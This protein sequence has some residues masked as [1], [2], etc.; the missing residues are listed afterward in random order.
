M[1]DIDETID[2]YQRYCKALSEANRMNKDTL[3]DV[4]APAGITTVSVEFDGEGDNGQIGDITARSGD[5]A[6]P[7][8]ESP[9]TLY[10]AVHGTAKLRSTQTSLREA[11]ETLCYGYLEQQQGGWENNN[12]GY[13][14]FTF[15]VAGRRI[16]LEFHARFTDSTQFDY[17]F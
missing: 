14:E 6:V 3:F 11:I 10:G 15:D 12:G 1:T 4:L 16:D 2:S 13:G 7:L 9:V 17:S 5:A 8:P